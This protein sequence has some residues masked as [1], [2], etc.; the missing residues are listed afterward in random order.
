MV[1]V[2]GHVR[3]RLHFGHESGQVDNYAVSFFV[4][5]IGRGD[6]S[7]S[8][9]MILACEVLIKTTFISI[10][11]APVLTMLRMI[12]TENR[13]QIFIRSICEKIQKNKRSEIEKND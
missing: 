6:V 1:K 13:N 12:M 2:I 11:T 8:K 3:V 7:K 5:K 4:S 9:R 10:Q